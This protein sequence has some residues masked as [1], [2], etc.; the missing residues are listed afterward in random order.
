MGLSPK[1]FQ[2]GVS[3]KKRTPVQAHRQGDLSP[4]VE[5]LDD[6]PFH[7]GDGGNGE[8]ESAQEPRVQE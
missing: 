8:E 2:P 1:A 3:L 7:S 4:E 5:D 6:R